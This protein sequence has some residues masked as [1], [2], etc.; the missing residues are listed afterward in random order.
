[1][2]VNFDRKTERLCLGIHYLNTANQN[3]YGNIGIDFTIIE[4]I[5]TISFFF[6]SQPKNLHPNKE[7]EKDDSKDRHPLPPVV[8][9]KKVRIHV[10]VMRGKWGGGRV[11]GIILIAMRKERERVPRHIFG[12]FTI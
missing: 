1:M 2:N 9:I 10:A 5:L 4:D 3:M 8:G 12:N 7:Q 6:S 11:G